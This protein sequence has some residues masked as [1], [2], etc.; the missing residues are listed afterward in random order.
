MVSYQVAASVDDTHCYSTTNYYTNADL[1]FGEWNAIIKAFMRFAL[2]IPK[3]STILTAILQV[4]SYSNYASMDFD[5][6]IKAEDADSADD[7]DVNPFARSMIATTVT[8]SLTDWVAAT[9]YNSPDISTIVQAI[10]NRAGWVSGNYIG[11]CF[12]NNLAYGAKKYRRGHQ[13]DYPL[14]PEY[15]CILIVT[16]TPPSAAKPSSGSAVMA[17]MMNSAKW[18]RTKQ[19]KDYTP[20]RLG[21]PV[22]GMRKV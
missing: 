9:W 18:L 8:W 21:L 6:I 20:R 10:V 5:V 13:W 14:H 22:L 2:T 19:P 7:Y 4:K 12:D 3:N 15:A 17:M 11:T 1:F 16:Y